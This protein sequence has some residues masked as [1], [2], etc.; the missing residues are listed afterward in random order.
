MFRDTWGRGIGGGGYEDLLAKYD[1]W[2]Y[3]SQ[4][5]YPHGVFWGLLAHYG[6][7]GLALYGWFLVRVAGMARD[8]NQWTLSRSDLLGPR[9]LALCM[10]GAMV[11]YWAWSFVEFMYDDKPFWEFL[12]LF[13][14]TWALV[15]ERVA[16]GPVP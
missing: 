4:Y 3:N 15:R 6:L 10:V 14:V 2:L 11:G 1:W 7:V 9:I 13:T 5:R 16:P 8:L 12:G